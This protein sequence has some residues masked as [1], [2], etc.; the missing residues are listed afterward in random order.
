MTCYPFI[1]HFAEASGHPDEDN[2]SNDRGLEYR[3][4]RSLKRKT[5]PIKVLRRRSVSRGRHDGAVTSSLQDVTEEQISGRSISKDAKDDE[6]KVESKQTSFNMKGGERFGFKFF[7]TQC[8]KVYANPNRRDRYLLPGVTPFT[9]IT[10]EE[11]A[12][13]IKCVG[14]EEASGNPLPFASKRSVYKYWKRKYG[15]TSRGLCFTDVTDVQLTEEEFDQEH[16][17]ST[18]GQHH[19]EEHK[20][21]TGQSTIPCV[22]NKVKSGQDV[23]ARRNVGFISIVAD[24]NDSS[25]EMDQQTNLEVVS[26]FV[27]SACKFSGLD[28]QL[29]QG[30]EPL[31]QET[32]IEGMMPQKS[33]L[34]KSVT[35][36]LNCD[37]PPT[38][39]ITIN[40][41]CGGSNTKCDSVT[42][43]DSSQQ[44]APIDTENSQDTKINRG[45]CYR[46]IS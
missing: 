43:T 33:A 25:N 40:I 10:A 11:E 37:K 21:Q 23:M 22:E 1:T 26:S 30:N 41:Y 36:C 42:Q 8:A 29:T 38:G 9:D 14:K 3:R 20:Q 13:I 39:P 4:S 35:D 31:V 15:I 27:H 5:T 18:R 19:S 45:W 2:T 6:S 28:S 12:Y 32:L 34:Q 17:R 44:A 16:Q 46:R 24:T 7:L